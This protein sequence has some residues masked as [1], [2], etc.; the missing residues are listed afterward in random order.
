MATI[1]LT[2]NTDVSALSLA[3]DDT[4]DLAGFVLTFDV[5]PTVTGIQVTTPGTNGTC[6]FPVACVIPTWDFFGG[7]NTLPGMIDTLPANCEIGTITGG[8]GANSRGV[9]TNDGIIGSAFAGSGLQSHAVLTN[10]GT[11][12]SVVGGLGS[13]ANGIITNNGTVT[14]SEGG[15][16][17]R[18]INTNNGT[19]TTAN[20]SATSTA[21]GINLNNGTVHTSNAGGSTGCNGTLE[22]RGIVYVSNGGAFGNANGV[23]TNNGTVLV[24]NGGTI[25]TAR[26]VA[27]N[28][29]LCLRLTDNTGP[30]V[31]AWR[32]AACFVEGPF[33]DGIIPDNLKTIY[34]LGPLS[35]SA[36]IA[37]D[38]TVITLSEGTGT[39]GFTGIRAIS[40]RL[41]T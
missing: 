14:T 35:E 41:G 4:I 24:A 15:A 30:G 12:T 2:A 8:A 18:G 17:G 40:R 37:G 39:A 3:N 21:E 1:T 6:V 20:G 22:N 34:S 32:G 36:T 26:G 19:V 10:N 16:V 31:F 28:N 25:S 13:N 5:Q 23:V 9:S 27:T 7:S 11:V 38:A 29:G 33:I